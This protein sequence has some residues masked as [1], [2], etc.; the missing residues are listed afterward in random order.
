MIRP[1]I[2]GLYYIVQQKSFIMSCHL[3]VAST[4]LPHDETVAEQ[5]HPRDRGEWHQDLELPLPCFMMKRPHPEQGARCATGE[6][7]QNQR[8][9]RNPPPMVDRLILVE[10]IQQK[11]DDTHED[12]P[13][14]DALIYILIHNRF[15]IL[16]NVIV[17]E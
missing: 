4:A 7:R 12:D 15:L 3:V 9:L 6:R 8:L 2:A 17:I 14:R 5:R 1:H 11:G 16:E 13:E 10:P